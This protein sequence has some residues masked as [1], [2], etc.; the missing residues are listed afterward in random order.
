MVK[1]DKFLSIKLRFQ[2]NEILGFCPETTLLPNYANTQ[3]VEPK[4][5]MA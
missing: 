3:V 2:W 1:F 5:T 4:F